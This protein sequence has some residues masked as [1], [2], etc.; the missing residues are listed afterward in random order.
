MK[1]DYYIHLNNNHSIKLFF[2]HLLS[3]AYKNSRKFETTVEYLVGSKYL[4]FP[5]PNTQLFGSKIE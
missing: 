2:Y 4:Q 5:K 3:S 1:A